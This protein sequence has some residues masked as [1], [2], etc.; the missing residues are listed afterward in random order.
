MSVLHVLP[1][2]A[3]GPMARSRTTAGTSRYNRGL[4][5]PGSSGVGG[6][7][8]N[9]STGRAEATLLLYRSG[10]GGPLAI[11]RRLVPKITIKVLVAL[12]I[13]T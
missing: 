11:L 12:V 5:G 6:G 1:V 2:E 9:R 8:G 13:Y 7:S 3:P 10:L 4:A